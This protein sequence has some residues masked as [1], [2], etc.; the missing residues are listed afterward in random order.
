MEQLQE[1]IPKSM[2]ELLTEAAKRIK[3]SQR[4][5]AFSHIDADGISALAIIVT[6]I[7]REGKQFEWRNIHQI[8]SET[9][10]EIRTEIEKYKPELIIFTD[11]GTGQ[12]NL[13]QNHIVTL[14]NVEHVIVLDHHL[15]QEKSSSNLE[16]DSHQK[17]VEINP[18]NHGLN[19]SYDVSGAGVSFLL[20]FTI[21]K[22]NFDLA[23]LAV[24]GA[25]GDLQDFYGKGFTGINREILSLGVTTGYLRVTRDLTFFGINTRPLPYLLQYATDPYLPG[26]TG[27]EE[28]CFAFFNDLRIEL[29]DENDQWRTWIDL[30]SEEKQRII[31]QLI[32]VVISY[33]DDPLLAAGL[34]GDVV[35]LTRRPERTEMRSAKEFSTLLNA[36]GRNK[37]PDVGVKICLGDP[38]AISSGRYLLQQHRQNLAQSLQILEN[39]GFAN[40]PGFYLVN[41]PE[42]PD[43]IIG[44]VI[45]MAQ[46]SRII[47]VDKPVLGISESSSND[48]PL[49]K[50]SGRAHRDLIKRGIN[51]KD[52]FVS[53]A[54]Y[55]NQEHGTLVAEAGGHPMAA[56]AFLHRDY[57]DEFLKLSSQ[58]ITKILIKK[59]R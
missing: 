17:L 11:F 48:S 4:I 7:E 8:N 20:A 25:T 51:L 56:G 29:K 58:Q 15:P 55:M 23:E 53:V 27:E 6:A 36:C 5:M 39:G 46:G 14:E 35:V 50:L 13:I 19:G 10:V 28:A 2:L 22:D 31:Q 21:S 16:I 26:I 34:I 32:Q 18:Y 45:G 37:R 24:V 57:V 38:D 41:D 47:P 33:Y 3:R 30:D 52:V 43:T 44:V 40:M 42:I 1:S 9:I 54:E 12:I 59:P 49:I